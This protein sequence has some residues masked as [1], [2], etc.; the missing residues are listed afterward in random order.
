VGS[1]RPTT[2]VESD[3]EHLLAAGLNRSLAH[4]FATLGTFAR[5]S[6]CFE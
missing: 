1:N 4:P 6:S 3:G 2:H 5:H